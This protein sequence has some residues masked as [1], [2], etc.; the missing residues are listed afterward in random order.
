MFIIKS[1]VNESFEFKTTLAKA[2]EFFA[3]KTNYV[4]LMPNLE[5]IQT[6]NRGITHWHIAVEVP[7]IG[8]W[9]MPFAVDFLSS[10]DT[11]EW[12]PAS[13]EKQNF[14]RCV[15]HLVEKTDNLI[16]GQISHNLELRRPQAKDFH[17][18][19][20]MAGEKMISSEMQNEVSRMLKTFLQKSKERLENL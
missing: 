17:A 3:N 9:K 11:I 2:S 19:A 5:N 14:L 18:L 20:G 7:F 16:S 4:S 10:S 6:D 13:I 15:T 8:R 12:F 1:N